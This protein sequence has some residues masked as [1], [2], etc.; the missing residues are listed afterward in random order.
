MQNRIILIGLFL[1]ILL[2]WSCREV[3]YPDNIESG[4]KILV[5]QGQILQFEYPVVKLSWAINYEGQSPEYI[6]DAEVFISTDNGYSVPLQY[7]G[8]GTYTTADLVGYQGI[9]YSL[10]VVADGEMYI[11]TPQYLQ[12]APVIESLYAK[13]GIKET[14]TY[15]TNNEPIVSEIEGLQVYSDHKSVENEPCYYR[16]NTKMVK[17][18]V[19]TIDVGSPASR[20][21]YIWQV[22]I[23]DNTYTV[24]YSAMQ[25][26]RQVLLGHPLVFL[27]YYYDT[28]LETETS[29]APYTAAWVLTFNVAS[30]SDD[31]YEYYN[32]IDRQLDSDNQIFAP[33][34]SQVKS[35]ILCATD[36]SQQVIGVFEASAITMVY[37]AFGWKSMTEIYEKDL[38]WFPDNITDGS[39]ERFPPDFWVFF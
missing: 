8:A 9:T 20:S 35:N 32:S 36:P 39:Q 26:D 27:W 10:N 3:Y 13:P 19:R 22:S 5:I 2:G 1:I 14:V 16:F 4:A 31:V 33:V 7:I 11:S 15:N 21:E 34:A 24:D 25:N 37:K 12:S 30:I 23:L 17:Q 6:E 18:M 29:T 28:N 38:E